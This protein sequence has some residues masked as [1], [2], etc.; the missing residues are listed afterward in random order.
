[1]HQE[2]IQ[3]EHAADDEATF[4]RDR[5]ITCQ[6][7]ALYVANVAYK[8][9]LGDSR[10]AK[11]LDNMCDALP[12]IMTEITAQVSKSFKVTD[13]DA[14]FAETLRACIADRLWAYAAVEHARLD[15]GDGYGY[16][17]D[18]LADNL[19]NGA[20]PHDTRETALA[21]PK[22]IRDLAEAEQAGE[23]R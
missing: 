11:S 2:T 8:A 5:L 1:M 4:D 6:A 9:A 12:E 23:D 22:R 17:F 7:A 21:A 13:A 18:L 19:R 14:E 10:P 3:T 20:D 16:L 15:A